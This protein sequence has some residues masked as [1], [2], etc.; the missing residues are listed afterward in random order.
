MIEKIKNYIAD[1][2]VTVEDLHYYQKINKT[3]EDLVDDG[4]F[5]VHYWEALDD[6]RNWYGEEF[7]ESR[8]LCKNGEDLKYR[9]NTPYIRIQ[10]R[11][12]L[13]LVLRKMLKK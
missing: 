13:V 6:M 2:G 5:A 7:D 3:L 4:L 8:Y 9:H 12:H 10:Y 1:C 11:N